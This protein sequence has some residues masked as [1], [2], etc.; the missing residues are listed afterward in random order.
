MVLHSMCGPTEEGYEVDEL[1]WLDDDDDDDDVT[2][3]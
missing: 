2:F 3:I 1:N